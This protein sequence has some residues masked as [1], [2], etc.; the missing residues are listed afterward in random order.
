MRSSP[1]PRSPRAD[2]DHPRGPVRACLRA[3]GLA[4]LGRC[5][6]TRPHRSRNSGELA[7]HAERLLLSLGG[8]AARRPA[9]SPG[10]S[11]TRERRQPAHILAGRLT[12]FVAVA[13]ELGSDY[14]M[15]IL[16]SRRRRSSASGTTSRRVRPPTSPD[17]ARLPTPTVHQAHR[18]QPRPNANRLPSADVG[19]RP[20][21]NR[22]P[23][24]WR[25]RPAHRNLPRPTLHSSA[26]EP[27]RSRRSR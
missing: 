11:D 7:D 1:T 16:H 12:R 22:T 25:A 17:T 9:P 26:S 24:H 27:G 20:P 21:R 8:G 18:R 5:T 10:R 4:G 2:L 13:R 14:W 23:A 3:T 19:P 15:P 6:A